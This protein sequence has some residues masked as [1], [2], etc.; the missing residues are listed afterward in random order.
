MLTRLQAFQRSSSKAYVLL[1]QFSVKIFLQ[2]E[3][4]YERVLTRNFLIQKFIF[5]T[6]SRFTVLAC[7]T[8]TEAAIHRCTHNNYNS[9]VSQQPRP[10]LSSLYSHMSLCEYL[11][12]CIIVEY[13]CVNIERRGR[14]WAVRLVTVTLCVQ[15]S[16]HKYMKTWGWPTNHVYYC[17][18][19]LYWTSTYCKKWCQ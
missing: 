7:Y 17:L 18:I 16:V 14:G 10:S 2:A 3:F 4:I 5:K 9:V 19:R 13:L 15:A 8:D 12:D 1:K 6:I 11:Y